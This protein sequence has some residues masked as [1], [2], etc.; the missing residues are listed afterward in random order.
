MSLRSQSA[1]QWVNG[2]GKSSSYGRKNKRWYID[3]S[4]NIPKAVPFIGGTNA[5]LKAGSGA[6]MKRQLQALVKREQDRNSE[7]KSKIITGQAVAGLLHN[8]IYTLNPLGNI[9]IGTGSG[10]RLGSQIDVKCV[11]LNMILSNVGAT[12][13]SAT[14][15]YRVMWIKSDNGVAQG[16]DAFGSGI[17]S[18]SV[19]NDTSSALL[20]S[21]TDKAKVKVLS[22]EIVTLQ[23]SGAFNTAQYKSMDIKYNH[24]IKFNFPTSNYSS[25][26]DNLYCLIIPYQIGGGTGVTNCGR[27]DYEAEVCFSDA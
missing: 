20:F 11:R 22:D 2:K 15:L 13:S 4:I 5:A 19:F 17:G 16:S 25:Y 9:P 6:L 10:S 27:V 3:T 14:L 1:Q 7:T 8:T 12:T 24:K 21:L 18:T 23:P 26:M